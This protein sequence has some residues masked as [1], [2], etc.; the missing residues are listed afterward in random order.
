[1]GHL[2]I[3]QEERKGSLREVA[4]CLGQYPEVTDLRAN[5]SQ[6]QSHA[7]KSLPPALPPGGGVLSHCVIQDC[8]WT[9][10]DFSFPSVQWDDCHVSACKRAI[11]LRLG[12]FHGSAW[13]TYVC[14]TYMLHVCACMHTCVC[15]SQR[16]TSSVFLR[17]HVYHPPLC[18]WGG[19]HMCV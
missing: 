6:A 13:Y 9:P 17:H 2:K 7:L 14:R 10:L 11:P 5:L 3:G 1:M 12:F 4:P 16:L 8:Y 19:A 18:L 15:A